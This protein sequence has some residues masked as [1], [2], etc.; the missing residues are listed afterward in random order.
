[1]LIKD[2]KEDIIKEISVSIN[3]SFDA[4]KPYLTNEG[5]DFVKNVLGTTLYTLLDDAYTEAGTSDKM[6]EK[7]QVLLGYVQRPLVYYGYLKYLPFGDVIVS[8]GGI[9]VQKSENSAPA[10][11]ARVEALKTALRDTA[12]SSLEK[13]II[14]LY[15]NADMYDWNE[16]NKFELWICSLLNFTHQMNELVNVSIPTE[17]FHRL[18]ASVR[19]VEENEVKKMITGDLFDKIKEQVADNMFDDE[20][21]YDFEQ[22]GSGGDGDDE[23]LVNHKLLLDILRPG[24]AYK[25]LAHGLSSQR[26]DISSIGINE[27]FMSDRVRDAF[28]GSAAVRNEVI[29]NIIRQFDEAGAMYLKKAKDYLIENEDDFPLYTDST[30]YDADETVDSPVFENDADD[31]YFAAY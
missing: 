1:M 3:F 29:G 24:I 31:K 25:S 4:V 22:S 9:S 8:D 17:I 11:Q 15:A 18:R 27:T 2:V 16:S 23:N 12:F 14:F 26:V 13:L 19:F 10:S 7:Y 30:D 5:T 21:P 28:Y 20:E 6:D